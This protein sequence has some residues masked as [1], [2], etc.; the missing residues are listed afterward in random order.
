MMKNN[1]KAKQILIDF[2]ISLL[3]VL[4]FLKKLIVAFFVWVIFKP[5]RFIFKLI[6]YKLFV[7]LYSAYILGW[8]KLREFNQRHQSQYA[9]IKRVAAPVVLGII[10]L[11]IILNNLI[12][13]PD[14]NADLTNIMYTAPAAHLIPN[15]FE[16][17]PP[18]QLITETGPAAPACTAPQQYLTET[19]ILI[20]QP[21]IT[22]LT[23]PGAANP[24]ASCLTSGGES[25][26]KPSVISTEAGNLSGERTSVATY[27]VKA[28]D[29]L[30]SVA[31]QFGISTNTIIW[32]NNLSSAGIIHEGDKLAILPTTGTLHTVKSGENL[33]AIADE[34]GVAASQ[35]ISYNNLNSS[36][37]LQIG[38]QLIIP[39]GRQ[40]ATPQ[41]AVAYTPKSNA[42]V[43]SVIK[44]IL[45]PA[46][47][48][49]TKL[50]WPTVGHRITQY[51]SWRHTGVDIAN[52][53]GTPVYAAEDGVVKT[54][55]WN[56]GGY[57]NMILINHPNGMTTRYGH[58]SK[59]LVSAGE[60]VKRGQVIMLMGS[61][62]H[63]TGPHLHFE[64]YV[65]STRVNP[66]NYIR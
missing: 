6:F 52:K 16:T 60:E 36:A 34:Y 65:G 11:I 13:K 57:G 10:A 58:A 28:G 18:E 30:A 61:T 22:T 24:E 55:G 7:K 33:N 32:A 63:S 43:I 42:N 8:K 54:A 26:I 40:L 1:L 59:I 9:L 25:L 62:G 39:G 17:A 5:L 12:N 47:E 15:E 51:Y 48:S 38:Q 35:I 29:T 44:D 4:I 20:E 19:N 64:V 45:T 3:K 21:R 56:S 37:T 66:L 50:L 2:L 53:L 41:R 31:K 46:V 49:G 14:T 27:T 23:T